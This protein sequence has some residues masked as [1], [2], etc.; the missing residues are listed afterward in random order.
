M[1]K[2]SVWL[3]I[4]AVALGVVMEVLV[5]YKSTQET[6]INKNKIREGHATAESAEMTG[7]INANNIAKSSAEAKKLSAE[8]QSAGYLAQINQNNIA[9]SAAEARKVKADAEGAGYLATINEYN[10]E[11]QKAEADIAAIGAEFAKQAN[12][13]NDDPR[14][15]ADCE[16]DYAMK[17]MRRGR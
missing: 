17:Q 7:K 13:C 12:R 3:S 15:V 14:G 2:L 16:Y 4:A 1:Q 10:V 9:K 8:A 5:F 6:I 11:I